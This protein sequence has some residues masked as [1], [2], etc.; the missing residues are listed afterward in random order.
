M[1]KMKFEIYTGQRVDGAFG[2]EGCGR[3]MAAGCV[4]RLCSLALRGLEKGSEG[5]VSPMEP[6]RG[7]VQGVQR[8]QRVVVSPLRG[9]EFYSQ[10]YG[11]AFL[12]HKSH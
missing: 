1:I 10:R 8:V 12:L 3:L 5:K 7:R 11:N 6:L 4:K 2:P 9:D